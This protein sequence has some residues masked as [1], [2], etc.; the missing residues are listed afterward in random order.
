MKNGTNK[1]NKGNSKKSTVKSNAN[2]D[3]FTPRTEELMPTVAANL[4]KL[5]EA[6]KIN[7]K[8]LSEQT[9]Y[10]EA[11]ICKYVNEKQFPPLDFF[12]ALKKLYNISIDD[13]ISKEIYRGEISKPI[14][15]SEL[16]QAEAVMYNKCCGTYFV[17]YLNTSNY[18]GRD[19]N[20]PEEA[21]FYGVL[22]IS[23]NK[24]NLNK[25][26]YRCIAV[27]GIKER[28]TAAALKKK[29]DSFSNSSDAEKYITEDSAESLSKK[30]YYGDFELNANHAFITLSHDRKDKALIIL[31]RVNTN[32]KEYIGGMGTINSVSKGREGMPTAQYIALSRYPISLS[33]EEIHHNLLLSHPSYKADEHA[34]SLIALFKKTY[35]FPDTENEIHTELEKSLIIKVNLERYVKES[36]TRNMFRYAKISNRDDEAWYKLLKEVSIK[37]NTNEDTTCVST[38]Q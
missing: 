29:L 26:D 19:Q 21:L 17:Y 25:S 23:E 9:G 32:K 11:A 33:A 12:F 38:L 8:I 28:T 36:L 13:F 27:L 37:D 30:T 14:N 35:M 6:Q 4:R 15:L 18:K 3:A 10:S 20:S 1:T 5:I 22:N 31:H 34:K 16:E 2:N 24:T 7:Q